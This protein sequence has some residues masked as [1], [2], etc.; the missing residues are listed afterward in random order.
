MSDA[1]HA[2]LFQAV[3]AGGGPL[4]TFS[5]VGFARVV[6]DYIRFFALSQKL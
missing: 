3:A 6:R 5:P 4:G 2:A 1:E